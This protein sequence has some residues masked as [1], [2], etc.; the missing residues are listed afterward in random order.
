MVSLA[1]PISFEGLLVQCVGRILRADLGKDLAEVHD[2]HDP[3]TPLLA[4]SLRR[5]AP[6]YR[7]LGFVRK[8]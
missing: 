4:G 7:T 8:S 1:A 2:Y 3:A 6:G 5:R